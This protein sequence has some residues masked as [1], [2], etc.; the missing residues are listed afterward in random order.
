MH[1]CKT[2]RF[3][4]ILLPTNCDLYHYAGNNPVRYIDPDGRSPVH[5]SPSIGWSHHAPQRVF[6]YFNFFDPASTLLGFD[7]YGT[8]IDGNDFSVRMWKGSYGLAGAG[9]ELGLYKSNGASMNR[10]DLNKLGIIS[11]S[12]ELYSEF[13]GGFLL[14]TSR[15]DKP[16]FWTTQFHP[17]LAMFSYKDKLTAM[18][19]LNFDK[20]E[21]AE[22]FFNQISDKKKEAKGYFWNG[23]FKK[24]NVEFYLS[25]DKKSVVFKYGDL[26]K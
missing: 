3:C 22:N 10:D 14:G 1:D 16:S 5:F 21:H 13:E 9:C 25:D 7:I 12:S 11:S 17:L 20:E 6:G 2:L 24:E 15:E 8:R 19:Q 18:F 26:D 4:K 23:L